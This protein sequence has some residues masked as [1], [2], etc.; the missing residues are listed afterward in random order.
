MAEIA[1]PTVTKLTSTGA[2]WDGAAADLMEQLYN[3]FNATSVLWGIDL[4][5]TP[6]G[7]PT[8]SDS[9]TL[10]AAGAETFQINLRRTTAAIIQF[11]V[12]PDGTITN[13]STKAGLSANA[14]TEKATITISSSGA[15]A[16]ILEWADAIMILI[17]NA[18]STAHPMGAHAGKIF[19]PMYADDASRGVDGLGIL[20]G[21]PTTANSVA[22][23]T[24]NTGATYSFIRVNDTGVPATDWSNDFTFLDDA[25][26]SD[27]SLGGAYYFSPHLFRTKDSNGRIIGICKYLIRADQDRASRT[28]LENG[29][30]VGKYL[31]IGGATDC[32]LVPWPDATP[33]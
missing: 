8:G 30:A 25:P 14:C 23:W 10:L 21:T 33:P 31:H 16:L 1:T 26:N 6:T 24:S 18:A 7:T 12:D 4:A 29:L 13:S 28:R 22:N 11:I 32:L 9:F 17:D 15:Y 27:P 5:S 3:Y 19:T 20:G 2:S